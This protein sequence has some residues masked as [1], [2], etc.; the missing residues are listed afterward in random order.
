MMSVRQRR[1][2]MGKQQRSRIAWLVVGGMV[3][4]LQGCVSAPGA[5]AQAATVA[6]RPETSAEVQVTP[7]GYAYPD[8]ATFEVLSWNVEHFV[9]GLDDPYIDNEREDKPNADMGTRVA[10]LAEALRKADADI[11]VLQ[12]FESTK[13]L[14]QFAAE[15]LAGMDYAFFA[16]APSDNW[17][18]NVVVMSKFPLGILYAY[19]NVTTPVVDYTN[20]EGLTETQNNINT[21][22]WSVEVF[23]AEDYQFILTGLHLKA[24]RGERNEA[25][26]LGQINFLKQQFTRF[27]NAN[28]SQNLLIAGDLNSTL[29]SREIETL[30]AGESEGE[31][32]YDP[33]P[34]DLLTHPADDP[35]RRLDYVLVNGNMQ[36]EYQPGSAEV[37]DLLAPEKRRVL[38]DHLPLSITFG[39]GD[40]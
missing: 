36:K 37:P 3:C 11:V 24:G 29:G 1:M 14:R 15:Q 4:V 8:Q 13:Y 18:M 19:G 28:A 38:S 34:A 5:G 33:L 30:K 17:Y 23:P 20:E 2:E 21:R 31:T 12:E 10:Y 25:M 26:R 22:M 39:R 35:S 16:S 27:L 9:D 6:P 7:A 40:R 32:F